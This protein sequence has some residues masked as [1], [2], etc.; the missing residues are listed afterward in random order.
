MC[1]HWS[2]HS[3][4]LLWAEKIQAVLGEGDSKCSDESN[5]SVSSSIPSK[6]EPVSTLNLNWPCKS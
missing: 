1:V 3:V 6:M 2:L 5:P 4:N